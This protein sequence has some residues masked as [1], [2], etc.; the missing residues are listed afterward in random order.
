MENLNEV[1]KSYRGEL[2]KKGDIVLDLGSSEGYFSR[3]A[4]DRGA[5]VTSFDARSDYAVGPNDGV[6]EIKGEGLGA[7][8]IP[9][10][11]K[12]PMRSL[13]TILSS[14]RTN[15]DFLKCDIE[16]GE[17]EIFNC[18]LNKVK[19]IAIEFH[20]WTLK[21][22]PEIEGLGIK[23]DKPMPKNAVNK[24]IKFLSQTHNVEVVG[25]KKAGGYIYATKKI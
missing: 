5:K 9:N 20:V 12:T 10:Q 4:A 21:G 2:I 14:I 13:K 11:G 17:Y 3:W 1:W 7:F 25:D 15:I 6:C 18:G 19:Y 22:D 24:L 23:E 8:I 16:G